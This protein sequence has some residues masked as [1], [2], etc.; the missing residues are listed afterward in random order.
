MYDR[1]DLQLFGFA[2]NQKSHHEWWLSKKYLIYDQLATFRFTRSASQLLLIGINHLS[3]SSFFVST[4]LLNSRVEPSMKPLS[5][6]YCTC[7]IGS[8]SALPFL[9][10][11]SIIRSKKL[12]SYW[13]SRLL[14]T[15]TELS[16]L[17]P[18]TFT[19]VSSAMITTNCP[20][21]NFAQPFTG[22]P[23]ACHCV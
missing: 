8:I 4:T 5:M 19:S 14:I 1:T 21:S 2:L 16:V 7:P 13:R 9:K 18:L 3:S 20:K 10:K 22:S 17:H 11:V 23:C 6:A 15:L 12:T